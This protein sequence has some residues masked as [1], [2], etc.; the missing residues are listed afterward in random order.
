MRRSSGR[1]PP[2]RGPALTGNAQSSTQTYGTLHLR[3]TLQL[4]AQGTIQAHARVTLE[5]A[6]SIQFADGSLA[7]TTDGAPVA[8]NAAAVTLGFRFFSSQRL[9]ADASYTR[10]FAQHARDQAARPSVSY[11]F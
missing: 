6:S 9:T 8:R 4:D 3:G 5:T 7:F 10:Q 11:A 2:R 1:T